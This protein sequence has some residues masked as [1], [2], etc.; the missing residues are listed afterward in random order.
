MVAVKSSKFSNPAHR[1]LRGVRSEWDHWWSFTRASCDDPARFKDT[2]HHCLQPTYPPVIRKSYIQCVCTTAL[3]SGFPVDMPHSWYTN[4]QCRRLA[5]VSTSPR[6]FVHGG[7]ALSHTCFTLFSSSIALNSHSIQPPSLPTFFHHCLSIAGIPILA[8]VQFLLHQIFFL[9]LE[10]LQPHID[11]Y[12]WWHQWIY[13]C[14]L[15]I[16]RWID[17]TWQITFVVLGKFWVLGTFGEN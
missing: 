8:R 7:L 4:I 17:W 11:V 15:I 1:H 3:D 14:D 5:V 13:R 2:Q 12:T 16:D 9:N 10:R 6:H